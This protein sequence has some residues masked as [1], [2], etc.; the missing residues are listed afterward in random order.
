MLFSRKHSI[1]WIFPLGDSRGIFAKKMSRRTKQEMYPL[2][3]AW[4]VSGQSKTAFCRERQLNIHTFNYWLQK[5][6]A[7]LDSGISGEV[8]SGGGK[9]VALEVTSKRVVSP[10]AKL[11][12]IY[13]NGVI[14][15]LGQVVNSG[16]L[17][18]LIK[19]N[20]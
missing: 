2:V 11:E 14:L 17:E 18:S 20:L 13:P 1:K 3:D 7:D 6:K 9:F 16:Y 4:Q 15:R 12:L 10:D 5:H 19:I 8:S